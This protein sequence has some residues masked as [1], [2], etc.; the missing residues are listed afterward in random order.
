MCLLWSS[1]DDTKV[2]LY[3]LSGI[4]DEALAAETEKLID[5]MTSSGIPL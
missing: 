1:Q 4:N 5:K 2:T 3:K